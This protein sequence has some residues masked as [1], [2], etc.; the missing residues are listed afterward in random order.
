M[1]EWGD[2]ST[3]VDQTYETSL[4]EMRWRR[5]ARA[6]AE[7]IKDIGGFDAELFFGH[8]SYAGAGQDLPQGWVRFP[9]YPSNAFLRLVRDADLLRAP[10]GSVAAYRPRSTTSG[11]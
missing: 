11:D 7:R 1:T 9:K 8:R 3:Y 4:L 2:H 10:D 6:D 5:Q